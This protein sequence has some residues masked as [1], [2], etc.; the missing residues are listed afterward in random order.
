MTSIPSEAIPSGVREV[1]EGLAEAG[2]RAWVVGG[3]VRDRLLG[4][5]VSDW[6]IASSAEPP[7]V[8]RAFRKVIPTGI[9]HGTVTVLWKGEAY[10][11]TTLRGEGAYSDGRRPDEVFFVKTI[12]E[13]LARRDFTVNALAYDPT[14]GELV[15]PYGG[16]ADLEA[17][18][19]RAVGVP[20]E[21]FAE[22]GLRILRGARFVA[23]LEF[24]LDPETEA[25][26][27]GALDVYARVS[28]E[29]VR[30]EWL[31]TLRAKSPSRAL[32]V[33]LRTGI[34]ART[35]P[36]LAAL[37]GV[38]VAGSS[39]DAWQVTLAALDSSVGVAPRVAALLHGLGRA[40]GSDEY[41]ERSADRAD[42]WMRD[43]RFSNDERKETVHVIRAHRDLPTTDPVDV[44]RFLQRVE[45]EHV[46]AVLALA[47]SVVV[48]EGGDPKPVDAIAAVAEVQLSEGVPLRVGDLPVSGRDV[49]QRLG[50]PGKAVGELLR[51]LLERAVEDPT[52]A[53]RTR[54]LALLDELVE[55]RA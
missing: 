38:N 46:N 35:C 48:A 26:F 13:D 12:E 41:A 8:K 19:L 10:E 15:D 27:Q 11:V 53:E 55:A 50:A 23:S 42:A 20:A 6:D 1:C 44:R 24:E 32:E 51:A 40:Q 5:E 7:E 37:P 9:D 39:R 29:R 30:E 34:L 43:Y 45:A 47:R 3:C 33:M 52:M 54:M 31:K 4:R 22:D 49:I 14:N 18:R 21:R 36:A 16:V 28:P 25:A 2:H 17:R